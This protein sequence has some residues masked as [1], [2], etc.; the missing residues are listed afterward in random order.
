LDLFPCVPLRSFDSQTADSLVVLKWLPIK[1]SARLV[2]PH[3]SSY[4]TPISRRKFRPL[5]SSSTTA[6]SKSLFSYRTIVL[7]TYPWHGRS[8]VATTRRHSCQ[9]EPEPCRHSVNRVT[10]YVPFPAH[11]GEPD[12]RNP[13][14]PRSSTQ[15]GSKKPFYCYHG[16][17]RGQRLPA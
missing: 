16:D 2:G 1:Q 6:H 15:V 8:S 17:R 3:T 4:V 12:E 7:R 11:Y 5:P 13:K 9:L 14:V 10:V